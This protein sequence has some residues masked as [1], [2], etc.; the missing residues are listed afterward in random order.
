MKRIFLWIFLVGSFINA[1]AQESFPI[2]G[3]RDIRTGVYAFT[4]ATIV[5]NEK[6]KLE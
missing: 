3:I 5:Q 4:G 1:N 2:N 6:N